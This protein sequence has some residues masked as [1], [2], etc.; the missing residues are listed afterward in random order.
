MSLN[1]NKWK[2][3]RFIDSKKQLRHF[4]EYERVKYGRKNTK[5]PLMCIGENSFIW[6]H[7]VLLRKTEYY[8]NTGNKIMGLIYRVLLN[9]YQNKHHIH[10]PINTFDCGLKL[11]HLGPILVNGHV[12]GGKDISLHINTSIVAGG[13]NSGTPELEDGVVVGV[14]AVILGDIKLAKNIAVGANAVVNK[15]FDEEN[16]SIAGVPA[17]KISDNGRLQWNEKKDK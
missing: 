1:T 10:I 16:I 3:R 7:N 12:R 9:R 6:K 17:K 2:T 15:T 11:M 5:I 13:T 8:V 14:G 4:L